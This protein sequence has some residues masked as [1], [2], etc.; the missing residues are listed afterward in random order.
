VGNE[1]AMSPDAASAKASATAAQ[2]GITEPGLAVVE[3]FVGSGAD[4]VDTLLGDVIPGA[5]L[6]TGKRRR[7]VLV[8]LEHVYVFEGKRFG[9]VGTR[10]GAY[11][12]APGVMVRGA[13]SVRFPDGQSVVG[14]TD[15]QVGTLARA[16]QV[17]ALLAASADYLRMGILEVHNARQAG[18]SLNDLAT[19][20]GLTETGLKAA[21]ESV[22]IDFGVSAAEAV[23]KAA[24]ISGEGALAA[25]RGDSPKSATTGSRILDATIGGGDLEFREA[26]EPRIVLVTDQHIYVFEGRNMSKPGQLISRFDVAQAGLTR[27]GANL[28]LP[29]G[30]VIIFKSDADAKRLA[31]AA[32]AG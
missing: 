32:S 13:D 7:I 27:E 2:A 14:L 21:L 28:S 26:S 12:I 9:G 30:G 24:A 8:A 3:G 29:D 11:E 18:T 17:A 20:Q 23:M 22:V 25:E 6:L 31:D 4:A 5:S 1:E 10:L 15:Y 16:A 19:S